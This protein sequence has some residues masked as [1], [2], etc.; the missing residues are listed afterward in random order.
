MAAIFVGSS[1]SDPAVP[2][3]VSDVSLHVAG[4][5]GLTLLISRALARGTWSGVTLLTLSA[6]WTIAVVYGLT[7]EW[8]QSFVP[9]RHAELRDVG[10][11][12]IGAF[13]AAVSVAAWGIIRRL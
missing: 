3:A 2:A 9:N 4:Y 8:H 5:F 11:N 13:A 6:A 7:I 10:S 1:I 12:A